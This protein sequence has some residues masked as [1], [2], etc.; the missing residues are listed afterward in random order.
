MPG[1]RKPWPMSRKQT[2]DVALNTLGDNGKTASDN[3]VEV[4][5]TSRNLGQSS[6]I[7]HDGDS[8]GGESPGEKAEDDLKAFRT[9]HKWDPNLE[10][11][12]SASRCTAIRR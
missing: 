11:M 12:F 9:M 7:S 2:D 3:V 1:F 5:G 4:G 10:R 6:G 8:P